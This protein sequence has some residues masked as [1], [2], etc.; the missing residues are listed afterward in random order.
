MTINLHE[1][2]GDCSWKNTNSKYLN[3][4]LA[5]FSSHIMN[6]YSFSHGLWIFHAN[7]SPFDWVMKETKKGVCVTEAPCMTQNHSGLI[8][9]LLRSSSSDWPDDHGCGCWERHAA[10]LHVWDARGKHR[11]PCLHDG[12]SS[13][14]DSYKHRFTGLDWTA[15]NFTH[16]NYWTALDFI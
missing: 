8:V 4:N 10:F 6:W 7:L 16:L 11:R 9:L 5:K 13:D 3:K 12:R 14:E 15:R 2:F 1:M